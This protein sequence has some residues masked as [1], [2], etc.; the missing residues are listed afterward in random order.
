MYIHKLSNNQ[1]WYEAHGLNCT[2]ITYLKSRLSMQ[3]LSSYEMSK[4][5]LP[6]YGCVHIFLLSFTVVFN[7]KIIPHIQPTSFNMQNG[8]KNNL[9]NILICF[10]LLFCNIWPYLLLKH[11]FKDRIH[12]SFQWHSLYPQLSDT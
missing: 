9:V 3:A 11:R 10:P 12:F 6:L 8:L 4:L 5:G 7:Y 2:Q 1:C